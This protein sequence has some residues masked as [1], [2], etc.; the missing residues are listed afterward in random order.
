MTVSRVAV[1]TTR[2]R[3]P[4]LAARLE[5]LSQEPVMLSCIEAIPEPEEVLSRAREDASR[6]D[7]LL[8]TSARTVRFLWPEGGMPRVPVAAVGPLT[9]AAV[10]EA[11]GE[12][13]LMGD[14]GG[15]EMAVL[16]KA[17]VA[18]RSI[19]FPHASRSD[20]TIASALRGAGATVDT[21][22]V[23]EITP[24]APGAD[25]VD[26]V[27]FG[28]P[29]AVTGWFLSRNL[30]DLVVGAIGDTT[31]AAVARHGRQPDVVPS[32]PS[33]DL[34]ARLVARQLRERSSV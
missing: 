33:F 12:T 16:L 22:V 19:F 6:A 28:S 30:D 13:E 15:S 18:G 10:G 17:L 20:P 3:Y 5:A 24:L 14:A 27:L 11:G 2:D 31:A 21:A 23:Y 1:T 9:A 26:A 4:P 25:P 8:L 32:R 29:S 7:W 34:L